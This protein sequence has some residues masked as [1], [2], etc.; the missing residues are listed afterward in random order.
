MSERPTRIATFTFAAI[1]SSSFDFF[2]F[3]ERKLVVG[4]AVHSGWLGLRPAL[5]VSNVTGRASQI[6]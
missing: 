3:A 4:G 1:S 6:L 2:F 5:E